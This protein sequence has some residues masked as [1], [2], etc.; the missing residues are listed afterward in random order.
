[1]LNPMFLAGGAIRWLAT[2]L[3]LQRF[4]FPAQQPLAKI[5]DVKAERFADVRKGKKIT[6]VIGNEPFFRFLV[7]CPFSLARRCD[8]FLETSDRVLQNGEHQ[9]LLRVQA[10]GPLIGG[11]KLFRNE[12]IRLKNR[13]CLF[14]RGGIGLTRALDPKR[15]TTLAM[16][17]RN[18]IRSASP[19]LFFRN[20]GKP[21]F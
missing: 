4:V 12:N 7:K 16:I 9:Y 19:E 13:K 17:I 11:K 6:L 2:S 10:K 3:S 1:M 5:T 15:R 20:H 21:P 14:F 8:V 18:S